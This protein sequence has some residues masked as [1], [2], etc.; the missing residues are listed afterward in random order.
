AFWDLID[1]IKR[2]GKTVV[3]TTHYME[4]A[5]TLCDD[6]AIMDHGH[7]IARGTPQQLLAHHFSDVVLELPEAAL[8]GRER[9]LPFVFRNGLAEYSTRDVNASLEA[10]L[11]SKI[12][13]SQLKIRPRTLEDLFIE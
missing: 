6:I 13:L 7:I 5:Q 11:K 3:L 1:S 4:E 2:A 12:P 8:Q 9:V 10:L